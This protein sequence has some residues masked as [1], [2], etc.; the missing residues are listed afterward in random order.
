MCNPE[1]SIEVLTWYSIPKALK[2]CRI[3][4]N[5]II[6]YTIQYTIE[7]VSI[8]YQLIDDVSAQKH[9]IAS[10]IEHIINLFTPID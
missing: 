2:T 3:S 8:L 10:L 9:V 6:Q 1:I 4:Y 5:Y 7:H